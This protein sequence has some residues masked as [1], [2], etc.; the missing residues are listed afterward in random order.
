MPT[1]AP[2]FVQRVTAMMLDGKGDLLPVS[3]LP[4]DGTFPTGTSQWEKRSIAHEIPIWDADDLHECAMCP[5][6]CPHAAIRMNV[7]SPEELKRAPATLQGGAVDAQGRQPLAGMMYTSRS[8]RTTAPAAASASTS[9][10][11]AARRW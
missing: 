3:A 6:V 1:A 7:F 11:R 9:A 5:L 8:R 4:V 10:R 2:D